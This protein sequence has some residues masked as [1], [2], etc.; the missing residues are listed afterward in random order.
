MDRTLSGHDVAYQR[1]RVLFSVLWLYTSHPGR[2]RFAGSAGDRDVRAL[3]PKARRRLALD[4]R[5]DRHARP[6]FQCL[7][8]DRAAISESSGAQ[9]A[10][11][12]AGR[13]AVLVRATRRPRNVFGANYFRRFY[14]RAYA[15]P[16]AMRAGFE[17]FRA[18]EHDA[19]DFAEFARTKLT[20]PMLVLAGE[21]ASGTFLIDQGRLV[22][23]DVQGVVIKGSGHWLME[24]A[25]QQVIPQ[26]VAF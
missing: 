23:A 20:I 4:L 15:Q 3:R 5:S 10:G 22:D 18:F 21:K 24:E 14:A 13:A 11:P 12:H 25:I 16:G 9:S 17:V 8:P 26:L 1:D 7:R 2:H 6:L 19:K